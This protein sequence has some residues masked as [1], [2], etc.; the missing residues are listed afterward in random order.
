VRPFS[1][2]KI[3]TADY[4]G[5]R[6][7]EAEAGVRGNTIINCHTAL[8]VYFV[9]ILTRAVFVSPEIAA[10]SGL[11]VEVKDL[12]EKLDGRLLRRWLGDR[13]AHSY[14]YNKSHGE[15]IQWI[16]SAFKAGICG[17]HNALVKSWKKWSAIRNELIHNGRYAGLQLAKI[18]PERFSNRTAL[19]DFDVTNCHATAFQLASLLDEQV[20]R[21][22]IHDEDAALLVRELF[23][24]LGKSDPAELSRLAWKALGAKFSKNKVGAT[25]AYQKQTGLS[26]LEE[27]GSLEDVVLA[28]KDEWDEM[29]KLEARIEG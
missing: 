3:A 19:E 16:D 6:K 4:I 27:C 17:G 8:E 11:H 15:M 23:V 25:L 5:S 14:M 12:V 28:Y 20:M 1:G 29:G 10:N 9:D 22:I 24:R 13:L 21:G 26:P 2:I 18:W 7:I